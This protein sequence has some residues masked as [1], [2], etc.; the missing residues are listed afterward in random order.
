MKTTYVMEST[1]LSLW[2]AIFFKMGPSPCTSNN[3]YV[4]PKLTVI[5]F[6]NIRVRVGESGYTA[7]PTSLHPKTLLLLF[8]LLPFLLHP[9]LLSFKILL[10]FIFC[11]PWS[12]RTLIFFFF[13]LWFETEFVFR[14]INYI[15]KSF[16]KRIVACVSNFY[17]T[18]YKSCAAKKVK[19][20]GK[21]NTDSVS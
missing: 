8:L 20:Y 3:S 21:R 13:C 4:P 14:F 1:W 10:S 15:T 11:G 9:I 5:S 2:L 6:F 7:S 19:M 17:Q 16:M 18:D 12:L